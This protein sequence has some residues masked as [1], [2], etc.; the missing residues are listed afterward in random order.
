VTIFI[1]SGKEDKDRY[2]CADPKTFE[3]LKAWQGEKGLDALVFEVPD[4]Q[5]QCIVDK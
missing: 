4:R 3:M 5:V 1:R 2:V